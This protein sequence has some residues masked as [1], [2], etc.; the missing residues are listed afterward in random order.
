MIGSVPILIWTRPPGE[1]QAE[2]IDFFRRFPKQLV[3]SRVG[4]IWAPNFYYRAS[5]VQALFL[6]PLAR[7]HRMRPDPL[8][9]LRAFPGYG[10]I[11]L[12][13]STTRSATTT[14]TARSRWAWSSVG[15]A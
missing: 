2:N 7:L 4:P 5:T 14:L 8:Q 9:P 1:P 10:L 3:E 12:T 15:P 11:A 6:A 13:L